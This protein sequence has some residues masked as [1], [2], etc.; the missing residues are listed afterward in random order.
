[1]AKTLHCYD[2]Q[3]LD[4]CLRILMLMTDHGGGLTDEHVLLEL[5]SKAAGGTKEAVN[6]TSLGSLHGPASAQRFEAMEGT[7]NLHS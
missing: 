6:I 2:W 4:R 7:S 5:R 3:S 1:M